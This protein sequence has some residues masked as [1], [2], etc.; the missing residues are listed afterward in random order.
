M[1][2]VTVSANKKG[3]KQRV[4]TYTPGNGPLL[5]SDDTSSLTGLSQLGDIDRNLR[6]ADTN[7]E[8]IDETANDELADAVGGAD[9][10]TANTPN[11]RTNL[12]RTLTSEPICQDTRDQSAHEGTTRHGSRNTTLRRRC[13]S[14]TGAIL[15]SALIE[16]ALVLLSAQTVVPTR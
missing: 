3:E 13:R 5:S 10:D 11:D 15:H 9:Y 2:V 4:I 16:E 14:C 6:T 12:D 7:G 8:T 1:L